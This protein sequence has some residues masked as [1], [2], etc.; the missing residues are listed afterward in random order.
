MVASRSLSLS[1]K[2]SIEQTVNETCANTLNLFSTKLVFLK[3][4]NNCLNVI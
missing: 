4:G 1:L 2:L 3:S